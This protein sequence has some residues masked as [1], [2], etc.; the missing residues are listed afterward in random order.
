MKNWSEAFRLAKY[1]L[2]QSIISFFWIF[3]AIIVM[4]P[5][6]LF[7]PDFDPYLDRTFLP[8]DIIFLFIFI[9]SPVLFRRSIFNYGKIHRDGMEATSTVQLLL[10]LPTARDQI[11]KNRI[12][13][14]YIY[15]W[16]IQVPFIVLLYFFSPTI[17]DAS[18]PAHYIA[19]AVIWIAF[20]VYVAG[21]V[22][23]TGD[24]G[25]TMPKIRYIAYST[26]LTVGLIA[27]YSLVRMISN[28]GM[29]ELSL[30]A[31]NEAPIISIIISI[32]LA[33]AGLHFVH[34]IN[35]SLMKKNDYL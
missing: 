8:A 11:S 35:I 32:I 25:A 20:S 7:S 2:S 12:I 4:V 19:F 6:I 14:F 26:L 1:E 24:F 10:H 28:R 30:L 13:L 31:A 33:A 22:T 23:L 17:R 3:L 21:F 5:L 16:T 9:L 34:K 27:L 29:V 18:G 15:A